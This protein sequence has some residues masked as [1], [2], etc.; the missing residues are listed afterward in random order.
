MNAQ[1]SMFEVVVRWK[2]VDEFLEE[3]VEK[4]AGG[5]SW[6]TNENKVIKEDK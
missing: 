3:S 2:T 6:W 4:T 5:T 1:G